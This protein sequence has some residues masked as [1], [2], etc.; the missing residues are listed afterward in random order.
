MIAVRFSASIPCASR[1]CAR[2][3]MSSASAGR[4]LGSSLRAMAEVMPSTDRRR[5]AKMSFSD[6]TPASAKAFLDSE[7]AKWEPIIKAAGIVAN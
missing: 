7:I 4:R 1:L 6:T 5:S 2:S 3:P